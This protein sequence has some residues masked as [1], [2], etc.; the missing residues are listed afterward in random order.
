MI[1]EWWFMVWLLD[2]TCQVIEF[3]FWF[4]ISN[5]YL[6]K[7]CNFIA[8]KFNDKIT[9]PYFHHH[10]TVVK[11]REA[12][13]S[14]QLHLVYGSRIF[15]QQSNHIRFMKLLCRWTF[16]HCNLLSFITLLSFV[17]KLLTETEK[18]ANWCQ[19]ACRKGIDKFVICY[20]ISRIITLWGIHW[21]THN[22]NLY[23]LL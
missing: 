22:Q 15:T 7:S 23:P 3:P 19:L 11:L 13:A 12:T 10:K 16:I 2:I 5:Q 1:Y 8:K 4:V 14:L 18:L 6:T 9:R 17:F 21:V 20:I